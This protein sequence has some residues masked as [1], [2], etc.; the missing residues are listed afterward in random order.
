MKAAVIRG[1]LPAIVLNIISFAS[2]TYAGPFSDRDIINFLTQSLCLDSSGESTNQAPYVDDCKNMRPQRGADQAAYFKRDWP[3]AHYA[4]HYVLTGHQE[5]DSV[6]YG[7]ENNPIVEQTLDFGGDADHEFGRFDHS[8]G[9]QVA[10]LVKGWASLIMT[11]DANTG[12]GW[13]IG[14]GCRYSSE[15]AK[16]GWLAF[17]RDTPT[18]RWAEITH[19][20]SLQHTFTCPQKFGVAYLRYRYENVSFPFRVV[21]GDKVSNVARKLN[22]IISEHY[23]GTNIAEANHLERFYFARNLGLV[24]WERWENIALHNDPTITQRAQALAS[25]DRCP[26]VEYSKAPGSNWIQVGCRNWTTIV[27][28]SAHRTVSSFHWRAFDDYLASKDRPTGDPRE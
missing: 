12:V 28:N 22:V 27:R 17:N 25:S 26:P 5:S 16:L 20:L 9:G 2:P 3:D 7:A 21:E 4:P 14:E 11:Q 18:G 6:L 15:E 13:F 1:I 24:R 10:V 8:D 19:H 23:G